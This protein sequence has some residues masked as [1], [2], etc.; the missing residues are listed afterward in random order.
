MDLIAKRDELSAKASNV[1]NRLRNMPDDTPVEE[2]GD[3]IM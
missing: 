2:L 3:T 1:I